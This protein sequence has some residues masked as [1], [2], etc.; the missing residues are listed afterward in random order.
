MFFNFFYELKKS[1]IPVSVKEYL[2]FLNAVDAGIAAQR[3]DD[4]YYLS[5]ASLV[6]DERHLD[7]F[8]RVFGH[9]FKGLESA[10]EG[11]FGGHPGRM[12]AR[13]GRAAV[14]GGGEGARSR[15]WAAGTRSWRS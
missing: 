5:R 6:K 8:D 12:A 3:I 15:R 13:A 2:T 10:I 4:F 9:V 1:G 11:H 7:K 14:H